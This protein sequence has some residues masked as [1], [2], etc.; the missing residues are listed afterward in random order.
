MRGCGIEIEITFLHVLAVIAFVAGETK[1]PF[2]QNR[3]AAVPQGQRE[4]HHLVPVADS[5]D[6][7]F[8]P[9]VGT[10]TRMIVGQKFPGSAAG[11]VVFADGSP[12]TLGKIRAPP[13]PVLFSSAI[14]FQADI[15]GR[16][17]S[18]HEPE[19]RGKLFTAVPPTVAA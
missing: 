1:E 15:F 16:L 9:A 17:K 5:G 18:R 11:A 7:V 12:L 13:F 3:I 4:A 6:S 19:P 14:V 2:L 8:S 10:R